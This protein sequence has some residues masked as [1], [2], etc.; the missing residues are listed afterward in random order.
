MPMGYHG[1]SEMPDGTDIVYRYDGSYQGFLCCVAESCNEKKMPQAIQLLD[2][3]QGSLFPP[4][5]H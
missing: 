2:E 3:P 5:G 1:A 4:A